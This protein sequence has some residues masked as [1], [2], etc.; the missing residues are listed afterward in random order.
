MMAMYPDFPWYQR[1][2]SRQSEYLDTYTPELTRKFTF[3][4]SLFPQQ[5]HGAVSVPAPSSLIK[6][7]QQYSVQNKAW[8]SWKM[9][10][11]LNICSTRNTNICRFNYIEIFNLRSGNIDIII[12]MLLNKCITQSRGFWFISKCEYVIC[13][14]FPNGQSWQP[15]ELKPHPK[16]CFFYTPDL[17]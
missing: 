16:I 15:R 3:L 5:E 17:T 13:A 12:K 14:H 1:F 6:P 8:G 9:L 2:R 10:A 7:K 11:E 4:T